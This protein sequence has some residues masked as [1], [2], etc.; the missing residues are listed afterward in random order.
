MLDQRSPS[1]MLGASSQQIFAHL[2]RAEFFDEKLP[3]SRKSKGNK[4][5]IIVG[6]QDNASQ[7][8][9]GLQPWSKGRKD[10]GI[11]ADASEL[12]KQ[13]YSSEDSDKE[14]L[15]DKIE[16]LKPI[17]TGISPF[18]KDAG[19]GTDEIMSLRS[20]RLS[21]LDAEGQRSQGG[22]SNGKSPNKKAEGSN[23]K[24]GSNQKQPLPT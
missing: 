1:Y 5:K 4:E 8:L 22:S 21:H 3:A 7:T 11:D 2:L 20:M 6:I 17:G 14:H 24:D 15:K 9:G 23:T 10:D 12:I 16:P 13:L 19:Q 18:N